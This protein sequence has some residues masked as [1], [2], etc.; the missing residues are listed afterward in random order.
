MTKKSKENELKQRKGVI[1]Q[2]FMTR[3]IPV[4]GLVY[5]GHFQPNWPSCMK[6]HW[7]PWNLRV[8]IIVLLFFTIPERGGQNS[9]ACRGQ[10][11]DIMAFLDACWSEIKK[12]QMAWFCYFVNM[13]IPKNMELLWFWI[14][15]KIWKNMVFFC[16]KPTKPKKTQGFFKNAWSPQYLC[17]CEIFKSKI[18]SKKK[19]AK[20]GRFR[21]NF[22]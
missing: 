7:T 19:L 20:L 21:Q 10:K 1:P 3:D 12:G 14:M 4:L 22:G 11:M 9:K 15:R 6:V 8:A 16:R 5:T 13:L 18:I 2:E 17:K